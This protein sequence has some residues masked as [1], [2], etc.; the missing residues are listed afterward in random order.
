MNEKPTYEE[1]EQRIRDLEG[2]RGDHYLRHDPYREICEA[3][4][5]T[6]LIFDINGVI[7]EV[8]PAASMMYGYSRD[9]MIGLTGKDIVHRDFQ[10][11]FKEFVKKASE[12]LVFSAESVDIRK[13]G[14]AFPVEIRGSGLTYNG[15]PH[16]LAVVRDV[17]RRKKAEEALIESERE[18]TIIL[19]AMTDLVA[20]QD[21]DHIVQWTNKAAAASVDETQSALKGRKCYE[22]W[23]GKKIR[24][25]I[26]PVDE[27]IKTGSLQRE[28]TETPDGRVWMITGCPVK[29]EAGQIIGAVEMT[30]DITKIEQAE[31]AFR[32]LELEKRTILEAQPNHVILQNLDLT[33][34]WANRAACKSANLSR[35]DLVGKYCYQIWAK[36][37][38]VCP[39]CPVKLCIETGRKEEVVKKTPDGKTWHVVGVPVRNETGQ[40]VSA[41]EIT[42]DITERTSLQAQ[43]HQAQKMETIG[44]LAG[45]IAHDFNNILFPI[46]GLSELL[47]E[48][49]PADSLEFENAEQVLKSAERGKKL[50]QQILAFS[51]ISEHEMIPLR[52]QHILKDV[53]KLTRS[54]IPANI[55][56]IQNIQEKCGLVEGDPTQIHQIAMNLITNAYHAVQETGGSISVHLQEITVDAHNSPFF[57]IK[58]GRYA[59]L[60]ISDTGCGIVPNHLEKIFEPYFTTKAQGQGTGLGL[61]VTYGIVKQLGGKI[62]VQSELGKGSRFDVYIPLIERPVRKDLAEK[63]NT[64]PTGNERILLV[65]DEEPVVRLETQMLERLGYK[66]TAFSSSKE[67]LKAFEGSPNDFELVITDLAMPIMTGDQLAEQILSIRSDIPVVLCTGFNE[68]INEEEANSLGL[69]GLLRKPI[70]RSDM[71]RMV[72]RLIDALG[73]SLL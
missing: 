68:R 59:N 52:I 42:E 54:T 14:S 46:I 70:S 55:E 37:E 50:V 49:L 67:A 61:A 16:L 10:H 5:D 26:C 60:S 63:L 34:A 56:I 19:D 41:V 21:I 48:D 3:A 8:N 13:D 25:D 43:L 53:L 28:K 72:R 11:L 17:T 66:V 27:A 35:D 47:L 38:N 58:P 7:K 51:R 1:L 65:D 29:D 23:G 64:L 18:K 15:E 6:F 40:I 12:G 9:E 4:K 57:S 24:C 69:G 20:Y 2:D 73:Q 39:D 45:G 22:I 30:S 44:T 31:K 62:R 32:E 33:V 71:A 36:E